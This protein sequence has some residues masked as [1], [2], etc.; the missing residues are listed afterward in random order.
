[1]GK[2]KLSPKGESE[3]RLTSRI[4]NSAGSPNF[5]D[6][7]RGHALLNSMVLYFNSWQKGMGSDWKTWREEPWRITG[8]ALKYHGVPWAIALGMW[9]GLFGEDNKDMID[10]IPDYDFENYNVL[11]LG[12]TSDGR[13]VYLRWARDEA[14]R[15]NFGLLTKLIRT[16]TKEAGGFDKFLSDMTQF[17]FESGTPATNPILQDFVDDMIGIIDD[18]YDIKQ[19]K[20]WSS[21]DQNILNMLSKEDLTAENLE[22]NPELRELLKQ[23]GIDPDELA[24]RLAD[25]NLKGLLLAEKL[26]AFANKYSGSGFYKFRGVNVDEVRMEMDEIFNIGDTPV[27]GPIM[28]RYIKISEHPLT[29]LQKRNKKYN[30][31]I[32]NTLKV[33][34]HMKIKQWLETPHNNSKEYKKIQ[35]EGMESLIELAI[36]G[37]LKENALVRNMLAK[38]MGE[39]W[40]EDFLGPMSVAERQVF[41]Q[42]IQQRLENPYN[43][44]ED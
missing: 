14:T 24:R 23:R 19:F 1:M 30:E 11:P 15:L 6:H 34:R 2:I 42:Q 17:G 27:F 37:S 35:T 39:A 12:V 3:A 21:I 8:N 20:G 9:F 38:Y 43:K 26:K 18:D 4:V 29:T 33:V 13:V 22:K 41:I 31:K 7:G 44:K 28:N 36:N 10:A 25:P 16:Q 40:L 32:S 5:L